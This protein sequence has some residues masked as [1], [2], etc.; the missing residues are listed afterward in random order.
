MATGVVSVPTLSRSESTSPA[1]PDAPGTGTEA[2][3]I[4]LE[5]TEELVHDRL[6]RDRRHSRSNDPSLAAYAEYYN[7]AYLAIE[8]D[9]ANV[10]AVSLNDFGLECHGTLQ[11]G[12]IPSTLSLSNYDDEAALADGVADRLQSRGVD[13]GSEYDIEGLDLHVVDGTVYVFYAAC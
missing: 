9:D 4:D 5:A 3:G 2:A 10:E 11:E 6:E 1:P 13:T 12:R 8:Y 7:R